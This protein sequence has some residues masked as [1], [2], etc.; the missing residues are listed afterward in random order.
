MMAV[1]MVEVIM[2]T[3]HRRLPVMALTIG[4]LIIDMTT[5]DTTTTLVLTTEV[6]IEADSTIIGDLMA[7]E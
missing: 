5:I 7:I 3:A 2:A 4:V 6:L 1:I